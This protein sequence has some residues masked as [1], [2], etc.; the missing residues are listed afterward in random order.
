M[1]YTLLKGNSDFG[2]A[3]RGLSVADPDKAL[4]SRSFHYQRFGATDASF[5]LESEEMHRRVA[6]VV[7]GMFV[8]PVDRHS[9]VEV[10]DLLHG[11][12]TSCGATLVDAAARREAFKFLLKRMVN[13]FQ[14]FIRVYVFS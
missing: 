1:V 10:L 12:V 9:E 6:D 2:G 14:S 8:L 7:L 11:R 4:S 5:L 13:R 3:R